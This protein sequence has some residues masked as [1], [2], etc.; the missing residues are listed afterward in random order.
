MYCWANRITLSFTKLISKHQFG[1]QKK[2]LTELAAIALL[3]QVRLAVDNGNIVGTY[4]IN[5]QK[6]FDTI[7]HNKLISKLERYSVRGKE[8]D[9]FKVI[10]STDKFEFIKMEV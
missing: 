9:W 3:D 1:F 10:C 2:K 6:A 7:S 5:L 4:F 8:L